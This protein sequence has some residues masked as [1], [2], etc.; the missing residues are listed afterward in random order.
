MRTWTWLPLAVA[1]TVSYVLSFALN[2]VLKPVINFLARSDRPPGPPLR[3]GEGR[4]PQSSAASQGT[5][6]MT[7]YHVAEVMT[8]L[9]SDVSRCCLPCWRCWTPC[10]SWT[11]VAEPAMAGRTRPGRFTISGAGG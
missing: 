1:V 4:V 11:D 8:G 9:R 10:P 7:A 2:F 6:R 3:G 5:W